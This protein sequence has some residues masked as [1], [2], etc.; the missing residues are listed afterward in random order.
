MIEDGTDARIGEVV[1]SLLGLSRLLGPEDLHDLLGAIS[2]E[3]ETAMEVILED[4]H[5]PE[6]GGTV[7][8][9]PGPAVRR[10]PHRPPTEP[11]R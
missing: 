10:R 6:P 9:F 5:R 3:I 7:V 8:P 2:V 11:T 4:R 1:A